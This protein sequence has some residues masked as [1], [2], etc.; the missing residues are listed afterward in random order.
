MS[1]NSAKKYCLDLTAEDILKWCRDNGYPKFRA[2]QISKWLSS[3][4]TDTSGMTNI[5]NAM[6]EKLEEDF[7]F[8]GMRVIEE[9]RSS[10][11]DTRKLV[12]LLHD[13]N[14][15]ETVI[16][17]YK[18]GLSICISSQAGCK[19]G[20]A[21]CAS[22]KAGF[23]RSLTAG[24]MAAQ[25]LLSQQHINEKIR[26]VVVMGIGEPFDN[27][28][29]LMRFINIMNDPDGVNLGARHITVSTCGLIPYIEKFTAQKLQVN[30]AI[31]LHA[32]NDELRREL[33]PVASRYGLKDLMKACRDYVDKTGRRITFE[34]SLFN[35]IN[36]TF[37]CAEELSKLLKGLN[38][39]VNLI[40]ANE[41]PGSPYKRSSSGR[42][43]KFRQALEEKGI[44]ATLRREM[45]S[46]IMAACGQLRRG[47]EEDRN[48]E[49]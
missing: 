14:I 23:G 7:I 18:T 39:H 24:E 16:M 13:G 8:S 29:N 44:N 2:Q 38:C 4:V 3:G 31:S 6:R 43:A 37:A 48:A 47:I 41:F 19:M 30:L 5:P 15:I 34:Y 11:D 12:Y 25:V 49:V 20:C 1:E 46:D 22:A 21:F 35:G 28:D 26:T 36:D 40:A 27:Y 32:P 45:G 17:R 42:V 9:F 33:M 10:I